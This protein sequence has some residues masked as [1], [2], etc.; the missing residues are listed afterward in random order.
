MTRG[1]RYSRVA[2]MILTLLWGS[3]PALS[4]ATPMEEIK[5]TIGQ[6]LAILQDSM[7]AGDAGRARRREMLRDVLSLRFD[8]KEMARMS[9]GA[10]WNRQPTRQQEFV[11]AF[12]GF[13]ENSYVSKMESLK[14]TEVVYLREHVDRELAQVDTKI[15]PNRGDDVPVHYKLHLSGG[16]WKIYDVIVENVSLV[17][18][19]RSQ[20]NRV[21]TSATFDDLLR[22]L[23]LRTS[24]RGG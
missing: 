14:G 21:L 16:E 20:F 22:K 8:F 7:D 2:L 24:A 13:V 11:S 10:H 15:V 9:L 5:K 17:D 6:A 18:N 1:N 23:Q 4:A 19:Y 12:T 3:M